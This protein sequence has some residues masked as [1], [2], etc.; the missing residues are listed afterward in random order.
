MKNNNKKMLDYYRKHKH[1]EI[2]IN[3][4][5]NHISRIKINLINTNMK[6]I[7]IKT[8]LKLLISL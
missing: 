2:F 7:I 3:G 4:H 6:F 8:S 1:S 5:S